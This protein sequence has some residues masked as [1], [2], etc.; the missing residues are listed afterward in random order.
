[1]DPVKSYHEKPSRDSFFGDT[2]SAT[3]FNKYING[4]TGDEQHLNFE[5]NDKHLHSELLCTIEKRQPIGVVPMVSLTILIACTVKNEENVT[6]VACWVLLII[7]AGM[8]KLC[9]PMLSNSRIIVGHNNKSKHH[10]LIFSALLTGILWS[11]PIFFVSYENPVALATVVLIVSGIISGAVSS[12]LGNIACMFLVATLP[13]LS[14]LLGIFTNMNTI[15]MRSCRVLL[16]ST[17]SY[18]IQVEILIMMLENY[19]VQN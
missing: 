5:I 4:D 7:F 2:Y 6:R 1:M 8:F 15:R 10:L 11:V 17:Y 19:C 12:Y 16:Y 9:M 14:I 3:V 13:C 18:S